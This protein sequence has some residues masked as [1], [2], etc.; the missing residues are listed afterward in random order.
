MKP[1]IFFFLS[2]CLGIDYAQKVD[3]LKASTSG[4]I[5]LG[6]NWNDLQGHVKSSPAAEPTKKW[7]KLKSGFDPKYLDFQITEVEVMF[8]HGKVTQIA[9]KFSKLEEDLVAEERLCKIFGRRY[10]TDGDQDAWKTDWMVGNYHV[11]LDGG[12]Q[13]SQFYLYLSYKE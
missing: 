8:E 10:W 11:R 12:D 2:L 7:C 6:M 1:L 3:T 13:L 9:M 4:E 5:S